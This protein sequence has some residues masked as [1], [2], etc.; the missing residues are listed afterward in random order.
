MRMLISLTCIAAPPPCPLQFYYLFGFLALVFVILVV[1]C[2]EITIVLCYFQLCSEDYH[3]WWR[4][5]FTSGTSALYLFA[6]SAFYFYSKLDIT[7]TVPLLM[8]FG[9]MTMVSL[10]FFCVTGTI[11]FYAC[12]YFVRKIYS[13]V[14]ID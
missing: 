14:K 9:Y 12:Y 7:K 1:T 10:A 4:S 8:Y 3:W 13:A 11:G 5:Y 2:T 6:Y